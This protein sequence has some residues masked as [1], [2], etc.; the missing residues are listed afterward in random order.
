M[1][2]KNF[3]TLFSESLDQSDLSAKQ[4]AVLRASWNFSRKRDLIA[5]VLEILPTGQRCLKERCI[6]N[7]KR[8]MVF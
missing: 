6:N 5:P 4:Q 7:L 1:A 3:T 8:R 2:N